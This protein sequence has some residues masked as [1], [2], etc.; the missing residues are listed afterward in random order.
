M[1]AVYQYSSDN[2]STAHISKRT[3]AGGSIDVRGVEYIA[4]LH[5]ITRDTE[6]WS[7]SR[8]QRLQLMN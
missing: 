8:S 2:D 1:A 4:Q 3:T 7:F 6:Y 5:V